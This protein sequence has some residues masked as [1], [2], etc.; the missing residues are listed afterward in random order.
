MQAFGGDCA[1][2]VEQG[3]TNGINISQF[4]EHTHKTTR[5]SLDRVQPVFVHGAHSSQAL[6]SSSAL[7]GF[8]ELSWGAVQFCARSS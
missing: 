3:S 6:A 1:W 7:L 4:A 8:L 5:S 2:R